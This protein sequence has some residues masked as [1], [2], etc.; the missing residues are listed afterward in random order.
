[1]YINKIKYVLKYINSTVFIK[2]ETN[3]SN[4]LN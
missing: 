3:Q 2:V 1:M 4:N